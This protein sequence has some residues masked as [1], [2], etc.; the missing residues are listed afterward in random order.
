MWA[1]AFLYLA[2]SVGSGVNNTVHNSYLSDAYPTESRGRVF[3]WHNLSTPLSQTVGILVFGLV[4]TA[5]HNWRYGLL[6]AL[7]GI[8]LGLAL[9]TIGE[10]DKGA[11][12]ASHILKSSGMDVHSQQEKAPRVLLGSAVTRL[13]RHPLPLLRADRRGRS[14]GSPA[15]GRR[16][17]AASSSPTSS[18]STSAGRSEVYAIIGLAAFLGLP[19]AY[20][21][22]DRYFRRAPQR[23]LVISGICISAYG[24]LFVLS[25]Y[26]PALWMC[27]SLQTLANAA[28]AP[29][30]ICIFLTLAATAPA[31]DAHHLLRHVRG[32][33]TGLRRLHRERAA[34]R[35][36]RRRRRAC[37]ASSWPS[38]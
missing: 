18:T 22:G 25:L 26:V 2:A 19:V 38:P 16:C 23:P 11:N 17:S 10:P 5:A 32:V 7:A 30:A 31:R 28:V 15:P 29:L 37:T 35:H 3:S 21:L 36:L 20:V 4:V 1:F 13:L 9:F 33:L 27:V 8:P 12:E 14:S 34:R 24:I 6:V